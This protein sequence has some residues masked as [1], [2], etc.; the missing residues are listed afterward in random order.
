MANKSK[1][2]L[3]YS[4]YNTRQVIVKN[5]S[6]LDINYTWEYGYSDSD[7]YHKI[8]QATRKDIALKTANDTL[9]LKGIF[10]ATIVLE[11]KPV[12]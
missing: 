4:W 3:D 8:G 5:A 9:N 10:Q 7:G 12:I 11:P 1:D 6:H 2:T